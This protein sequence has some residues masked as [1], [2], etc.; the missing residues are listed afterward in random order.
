MS[1]SSRGVGWVLDERLDL[2][3]FDINGIREMAL[4]LDKFVGQ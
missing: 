1:K 4:D 2:V 3:V